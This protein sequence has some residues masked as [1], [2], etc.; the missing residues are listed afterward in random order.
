MT[1]NPVIVIPTAKNP[2]VR[3]LKH[4][5]RRLPIIVVNGSAS[6]LDLDP[7]R[8]DIYGPARQRKVL[9][10]FY[11]SFLPFHGSSAC[12]NFGHYLALKKGYDVIIALDYD[13]VVPPDFVARHLA[14]LTT[15]IAPILTSANGWLNPIS[16]T[17]WYSR[18]F[19]YDR[20]YLAKVRSVTQPVNLVFNMGLW[21]HVI[22][23]NGIDKVL[24]Q[25]PN[26]LK[27]TQPLQV[28]GSNLPISGMNNAFFAQIV[29]AY[30]LFPNFFINGWELSRHDDIWGGYI[31][32][33][34]ID[35]HGN[36]V[37]FG[38]PV[39]YH[40]RQSSLPQ[41]LAHEH[42][43]H[44]LSPYFYHLVDQAVSLTPKGTYPAM[45]TAFTNHFSA[46]LNETAELPPHYRAVF[47]KVLESLQWWTHL[48]Q[49]V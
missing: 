8:F 2:T 25:P 5:P 9:G 39:I 27:L 45:M 42:Y 40:E 11:E 3:F 4:L 20:R 17:G 31:L 13:C 6:K 7:S 16:G 29:P 23:I 35:K 37:S 49:T 18:G 14:A 1:M 34:L 30:L 22:D 36:H 41:V 26:R 33:Q 12:R 19:P 32:K 44:L 47:Y 46:V 21:E 43:L 15:P 10:R 48:L 24:R 28:A 38:Q